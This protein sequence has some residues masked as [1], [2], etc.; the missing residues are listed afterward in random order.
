MT[1]VVTLV[2]LRVPIDLYCVPVAQYIVNL[3]ELTLLTYSEE[4]KVLKS[5]TAN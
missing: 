5:Q 2:Y 4:N 1:S 3:L